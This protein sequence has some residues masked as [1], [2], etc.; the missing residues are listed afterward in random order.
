M[1]LSNRRHFLLAGGALMAGACGFTPVYAPNGAASKLEGRVHITAPKTKNKYLVTRR[2]ETRLGRSD[3]APMTLS[4]SVS[5]GATSLGTTATGS[6]TRKHRTGTL[7]YTLKNAETGSTIDKGKVTN[8]T[9]YSLTSNTAATLASERAASER[10]MVILA[11]Q[12][13][14]RLHLIDPALLP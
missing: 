13:I 10:L 1:S 3:P 2:L 11:D 4:F 6:T 14:D 12:L 7:N 5:E 8:F 9:G